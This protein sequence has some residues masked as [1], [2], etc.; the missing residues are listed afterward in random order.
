MALSGSFDFGAT[1]DDI[2]T[3]AL[4]LLGILGEGQSP[5]ADQLTSCSRTLN[6]LI[7]NMQAEYTNL[8]AIK[9]R[10]LFLERNK[11]TYTLSSTG[12]HFTSSFVATT[13]DA[14]AALGAS[15]VTVNSV[16][17]ISSGY[18]IGIY[19]SDGTMQWTTVNGAPVGNVVTLADV[20]TAAANEDA[21]VYVYATKAWRPMKITSI[22]LN[23]ISDTDTP[24]ELVPR[25]QYFELN[26]K[27]SGPGQVNQAYFDPQLG[28]AVLTVWPKPDD[29]RDVLKLITKVTLDDVDAGA[30]DVAFP[31]EWFLALAYNLAVFLSPKYS[32]PSKTFQILKVLADQALEAASGS[33]VE[34]YTSL[35]FQPETD[36]YRGS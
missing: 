3:E 29:P 8:W 18:N 12:D 21:V 25:E 19:L 15:T 33:D 4:E 10:Y 26:V 1:R 32:V 30:N 2:I 27:N 23:D 28:T 6:M 34:E 14:S 20:L 24:I 5:S 22:Y 9:L 31:Q 36:T 13:L 7:K 17:G 35:Y 16:A 11:I